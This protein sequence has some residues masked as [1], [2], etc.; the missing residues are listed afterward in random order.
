MNLLP[1]SWLSDPYGFSSHF[2]SHYSL[3]FAISPHLICF[4]FYCSCSDF[5]TIRFPPFPSFLQRAVW[6]IIVIVWFCFFVSF[7]AALITIVPL[8][9]G[10]SFYKLWYS[11]Y[12]AS[13]KLSLSC[14]QR[15]LL[16]RGHHDC[17]ICGSFFG[18][19]LWFLLLL[20]FII[21]FWI[22]GFIL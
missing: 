9:F 15:N 8:V 22:F 17:I 6:L 7:V 1:P 2:F 14:R 21:S 3:G 11:F 19:I 5:R 20:G 13:F 4:F 16:W 12:N 10:A 18:T